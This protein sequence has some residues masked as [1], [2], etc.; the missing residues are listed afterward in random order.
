LRRLLAAIERQVIRLGAVVASA[1]K[2]AVVALLV[3]LAVPAVDRLAEDWQRGVVRL[4]PFE[5]AKSLEES[6]FNGHVLAERLRKKM[7]DIEDTVQKG[8]FRGGRSLATT[9]IR[10]GD[11]LGEFKVPGAG[12]ALDELEDLALTILR[13]PPIMVS[14]RLCATPQAMVAAIKVEDRALHLL[15]P[16]ATPG[17]CDEPCVDELVGQVAE[18]FYAEKAPCLLEAYRYLRNSSRAD[19]EAAARLCRRDDPVFAHYT[20]G[21]FAAEQGDLHTAL[22]HLQRAL[23]LAPR[24]GRRRRQLEAIIHINWGAVFMQAHDCGRAIQQYDLAIAADPKAAWAYLERGYAL[25]GIAAKGAAT[26]YAMARTAADPD[27][28][29]PWAST[30]WSHLLYA[31]GRYREAAALLQE[32]VA[33]APDDIP[34]L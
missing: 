13:R 1:A 11:S 12:L 15:P 7:T 29:P 8:R 32:A 23:E 24:E 17:G 33:K 4:K 6:G 10:G 20:W 18:A 26:M 25:A 28:S 9:A 21:R 30:N 3:I 16:R 5:V 22:S 2:I 19:L 31:K 27:P 34:I 14:G